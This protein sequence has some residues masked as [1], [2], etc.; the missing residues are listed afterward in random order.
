MAL[1][2]GDRARQSRV[3]AAI[4]GRVAVLVVAG[5]AAGAVAVAQQDASP[6]GDAKS[7]TTKLLASGA[8]L[9]Q[10]N[11]PAEQLA[12]HLVGFHPLKDDPAHQME[13]H[14][15]CR[16]VNEDF[17]QCALFDGDG[18]DANLN[19]V[20]YIISQKLFDG[21]PA[22]EKPYWHPHDYE[23]LSGQLIAPGIPEVAEHRL[24]AGKM[25]SYGKT[26][27]LWS[28]GTSGAAADALPLG[29]PRLAWSFNHDG[30]ARADLVQQRDRSAGV[31]TA[32]VRAAR[33]DL[34]ATA[35]PQCGVDALVGRFGATTGVPGVTARQDGCGTQ[36]TATTDAGAAARTTATSVQGRTTQSQ[37]TRSF[38][39]GDESGR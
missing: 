38:D 2:P 35:Q 7:A 19:G 3:L 34:V 37:T 16:Q 30:E 14:H 5:V 9:V 22:E 17:A 29:P 6:P 10:G 8:G 12:I 21:L 39:H 32:K 28:T 18:A 1:R 36:R 15:Y 25:N 23:I 20:E 26:W 4:V 33:Q 31:D 24:M 11:A 13:A 27:H